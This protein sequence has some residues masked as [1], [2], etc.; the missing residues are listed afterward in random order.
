MTLYS[1]LVFMKKNLLKYKGYIWQI[2]FYLYLDLQCNI[3]LETNSI[4]ASKNSNLILNNYYSKS[5]SNSISNTFI[6]NSLRVF[7]FQHLFEILSSKLFYISTL[8]YF[9]WLFCTTLII[10]NHTRVKKK[11]FS[12]EREKYYEISFRLW[13]FDLF[14]V[15]KS[16]SNRNNNFFKVCIRKKLTNNYNIDL[17]PFW[18]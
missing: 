16:K 11:H 4:V 5:I 3:T 10:N 17:E 8:K 18:K 6:W 1:T 12:L 13:T 9:F 7:L 14:C 2:Y 15:K